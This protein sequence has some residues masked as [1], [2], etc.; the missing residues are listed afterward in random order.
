MRKASALIIV[1]LAILTAGCALS[2]KPA[3]QAAVTPAVTKPV[4]AV[5]APPPP[6]LSIPQTQV[7]LPKPQPFDPAALVTEPAPPAEAPP[8]TSTPRTQTPGRRPT[9]REGTATPPATNVTPAPALP[10]AAAPTEQVTSPIIQEIV[11]QA[12]VK[13]LQDQAA[14]R[15]REAR[16][17]VDQLARR[18]LSAANTELVNK[19]NSLIASSLDA[20][21][22]GDMKTADLL[23]ERAQILAKDL[24]NAR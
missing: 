11:P 7:E 19:I 22:K 5:P 8:E 6:P 24:L 15:R 4:P 18:Q 10:P 17:I 23:A 2:G 13:R 21:K 9:T 20:E 16:Q 1:V 3:K 14:G 12:E